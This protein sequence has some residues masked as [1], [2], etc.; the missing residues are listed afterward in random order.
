MC[1]CIAAPRPSAPAASFKVY[2]ATS[3]EKLSQLFTPPPRTVSVCRRT[4]NAIS[5]SGNFCPE[6]KAKGETEILYG[7]RYATND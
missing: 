1:I 4:Q 6:N 7:L 5:V 3:S 2:S